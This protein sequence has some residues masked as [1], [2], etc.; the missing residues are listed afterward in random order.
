[1]VILSATLAPHRFA[2]CM[3]Y[4]GLTL[5]VGNLGGDR[6]VGFALMGLVEIP[7]FLLANF[8]LER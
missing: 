2:N 5:N 8:L 4:Y 6:Y 7:S 1:M 3:L